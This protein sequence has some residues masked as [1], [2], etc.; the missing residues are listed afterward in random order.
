MPFQYLEDVAI[1]DLAFRAWG[2][3]LGDTFIAAADALVA[4][5][6][7]EL[8]EIRPRVQRSFDFD[9]TKLDLLLFD[10]L[11]EL[12][13]LKDAE[14]LLLRVQRVQVSSRD[15]SF[16]LHAEAAGERID[17][18]RHGLRADVKAVTL[19]RFTLAQ[20]GDGGWEATVIIDV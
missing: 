8:D 16:A 19:H 2:K 9:N 11:Q 17:P 12:I 5:M 7:E 13:Y 6:A 20:T 4:A 18:E 3:D 14:G 1:A 15:G 10:L